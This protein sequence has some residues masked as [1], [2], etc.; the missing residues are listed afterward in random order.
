MADPTTPAT[1]ATMPNLK[2]HGGGRRDSKRLMS[3]FKPG[4]PSPSEL[5]M[6]IGVVVPWAGWQEMARHPVKWMAPSWAM[7]RRAQVAERGRVQRSITRIDV[8]EPDN[9]LQSASHV[10][11]AR[12]QLRVPIGEEAVE[13]GQGL[14]HLGGRDAA[15]CGEP[16][17]LLI[18]AVLEVE[19]ALANRKT[20]QSRAFSTH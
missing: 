19:A 13:G 17:E 14:G 20:C 11:S 10:P 18:L 16:L 6:L 15:L 5:G 9:H 8:L 7:E 12:D 4:R 2:S 1:M 3:P